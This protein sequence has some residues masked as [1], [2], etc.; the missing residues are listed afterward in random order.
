[1][2]NK[3]IFRVE[4]HDT[5]DTEYPCSSP[6]LFFAEDVHQ[7]RKDIERDNEGLIEIDD[8]TEVSIEEVV[9]LFNLYV[10]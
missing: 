1:M 9:R 3:K 4:A 2:T 8:I 7:L 5:T 6:M 10:S